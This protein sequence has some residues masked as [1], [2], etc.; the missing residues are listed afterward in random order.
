MDAG[1]LLENAKALAKQTSE[2]QGH[3]PSDAPAGRELPEAARAELLD[4]CEDQFSQ[5]QQLQNE[6]ALAETESVQNPAFQTVS[7]ANA[8][9]AELKEWQELQPKL[10]SS[11]PEVLLAVGKEELSRLNKQL[12]MVLSCSQA[13]RDKLKD[14]LKSEQE[15]LEEKKEVLKAAT[16]RVT[17]LQDESDRLSEKGVLQDMKKK[18]QRV[19]DYHDN[20]L[21]TLSDLLEEHFPLPHQEGNAKKKRKDL[22]PEPSVDLISLHDMLELLMNKLLESP[23]E[24]YVEI[25]GTFWPPYTEMLLRYGIASRHPEDCFKIRLEAFY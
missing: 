11:N 21:E 25:N 13:K 12:E 9:T 3:L 18:I 17:A 19:K 20:L 23:H 22:L 10:L 15:W 7:R 1:E 24:P 4:E 8:L 2:Y 14:V 16:E 6:I 5:L